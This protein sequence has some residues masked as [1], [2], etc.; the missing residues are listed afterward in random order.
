MITESLR[1]SELLRTIK[2]EFEH[3]IKSRIKKER[4]ILR[5]P[6]VKN[7]KP[8]TEILWKEFNVQTSGF[9]KWFIKT[10]MEGPYDKPKAYN[11]Y[12]LDTNAGPNGSKL[13][14][15]YRGTKSTREG[16]IL[17]IQSHVLTRM[18]ERCENYKGLSNKELIGLIFKHGEE[19]V[20]YEYPWKQEEPS[21]IPSNSIEALS[22][23]IKKKE[24]PT[25][26]IILKTSA[27]VFLGYSSLD[28]SEVR[29]I[30]FLAE[31]GELEEVVEKFLI[32]TWTC[33]NHHMFEDDYILETYNALMEY[34]KGKEDRTVYRLGS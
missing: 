18:K 11:T 24:Y 4:D 10:G 30:T 3:D 23:G 19:G 7:K 22:L 21:S 26:S 9:N 32:P 8:I 15:I 27:G 17:G 33:Y 2:K 5:K 28:R 31:Y 34:M 25:K 29:L 16:Y 12:Y 1:G 14:L 6:Y 20:Y 13:Y